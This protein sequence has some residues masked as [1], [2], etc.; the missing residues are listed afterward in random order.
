MR[1]VHIPVQVATE[2]VLC[3]LLELADFGLLCGREI[4]SVSCGIDAM[5]SVLS[6]LR[7]VRI[8]L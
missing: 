4:L 6:L 8:G 1:V 7:V 3:L 5:V 2:S